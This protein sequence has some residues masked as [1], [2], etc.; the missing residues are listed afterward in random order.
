MF[1][2]GCYLRKT[3]KVEIQ[4]EVCDRWSI[5]SE[6]WYIKVSNN[7]DIEVDILLNVKTYTFIYQKFY[8]SSHTQ[9]NHHFRWL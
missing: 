3:S 8:V 7:G 6:I 1:S 2:S 4:V 9:K 5:I